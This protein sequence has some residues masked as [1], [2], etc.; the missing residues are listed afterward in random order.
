MKRR[1]RRLIAAGEPASGALFGEEATTGPRS[2]AARGVT[3][4]GWAAPGG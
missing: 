3:R 1:D 2:G 4:R